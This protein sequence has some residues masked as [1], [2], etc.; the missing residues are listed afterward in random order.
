VWDWPAGTTVATIEVGKHH[1]H[2]IAVSPDGKMVAAAVGGT[3]LRR[4]SLPDRRELPVIE[5][6]G[7]ARGVGDQ[8]RW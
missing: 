6:A 3:G 5:G 8:S 7:M 4:W 1:V 2:G